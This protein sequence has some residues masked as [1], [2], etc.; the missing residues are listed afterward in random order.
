M[1]K[2]FK[3]FLG[4]IIPSVG[5]GL[6]SLVKGGTMDDAIARTIESLQD[7]RAQEKFADL[8]VK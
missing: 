1:E 8:K 2:I 6:V 3:D 4:A 5:D 7:K